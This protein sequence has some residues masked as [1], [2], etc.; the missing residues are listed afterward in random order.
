MATS[1]RPRV[2]P[3]TDE[4]SSAAATE[5]EGSGRAT[6]IARAGEA[7]M[8]QEGTPSATHRSRR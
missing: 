8:L 3:T 7:W 1:F 2:P 4:R 5:L 6:A